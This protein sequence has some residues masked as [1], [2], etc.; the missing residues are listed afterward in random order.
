MKNA[1]IAPCRCCRDVV[2]FNIL[3]RQARVTMIRYAKTAALAIDETF[4]PPLIESFIPFL[5][6]ITP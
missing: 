4:R 5:N 3:Q 1:V 2:A 6:H